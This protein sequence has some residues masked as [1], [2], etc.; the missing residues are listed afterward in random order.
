MKKVILAL[1]VIAL[2]LFSNNLHSEWSLEVISKL[3]EPATFVTFLATFFGIFGAYSIANIQ[4]KKTLKFSNPQYLQRF[5][6][7]K[8]YM[9]DFKESAEK[10]E[11]VVCT[12]KRINAKQKISW[13]DYINMQQNIVDTITLLNPDIKEKEIL[14]EF[15]NILSEINKDS[16][17]YLYFSANGL[18]YKMVYLYNALLLE[19]RH[20]DLYGKKPELIMGLLGVK[21]RRDILKD[22]IKTYKKLLKGLNLKN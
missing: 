5:N 6:M 13:V 20:L 4:I 12:A 3:K 21:M 11:S 14:K 16:P 1:C 10:V 22:F 9:N 17:P 18:I 7:A 8:I 2:I 15:P 19:S